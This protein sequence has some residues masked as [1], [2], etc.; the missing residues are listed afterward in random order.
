[1]AVDELPRPERAGLDSTRGS[2]QTP[3]RGRCA[4]ALFGWAD[5]IPKVRGGSPW[6]P[7]A[8]ECRAGQR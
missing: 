7:S 5:T 4:P 3:C 8:G 6:W 1:M 2:A